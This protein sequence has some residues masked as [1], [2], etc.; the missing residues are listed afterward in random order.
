[1]LNYCNIPSTF[2]VD[3][4]KPRIPLH[5]TSHSDRVV[6]NKIFCFFSFS[7]GVSCNYF[8]FITSHST[9]G[10]IIKNKKKKKLFIRFCLLQIVIPFKV[11]SGNFG[12]RAKEKVFLWL[13]AE[14]RFHKAIKAYN[15]KISA[16]KNVSK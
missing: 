2:Q 3:L 12:V 14:G 4:I 11:R 13:C 16:Q 15:T 1:M 6:V 5:F 7:F 10:G 8:A 9:R